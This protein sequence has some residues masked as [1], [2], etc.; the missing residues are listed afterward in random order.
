[1]SIKKPFFSPETGVAAAGW[2]FQKPLKKLKR[3]EIDP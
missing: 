1:M 2:V 3:M